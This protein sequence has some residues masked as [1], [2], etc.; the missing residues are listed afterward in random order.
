[1]SAA[2]G[3]RAKARVAVLISGRGSNMATLIEACA[4]P[5]FPA[6]IALVLSNK[7]D[8]G[9]LAR[10]EAAGIATAVVDHRDFPRNRQ[11]FEEEV[12][13]QLA[14]AQIEIV[15]LAGFMRILTP[16]LI[17]R[18]RGKILNIHPSLL[19]SFPGLDTHA[20]ALDA[21]VR[22]HGATVHVVTPELDAGPII[23]QAAVPVLPGD[24]AQALQARVLEVEHK[25]YPQALRLFLRPGT[26]LEE[27][28]VHFAPEGFETPPAQISPI[29]RAD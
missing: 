6:E 19:P 13:K 1:M 15:C 9:G 2:A 10:A 7:P 4:D 25:L 14:A 12:E 8:A 27:D 18:R 28:R 23:A 20:R 26:R 16:W 17:G 21:G 5:A 29:L 22:W 11:A 3:D 24:D